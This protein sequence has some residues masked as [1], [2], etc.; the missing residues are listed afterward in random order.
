MSSRRLPLRY[1][2]FFSLLA[3]LAISIC[4]SA[5]A[6]VD[7]SSAI[8]SLTHVDAL[9]LGWAI[10]DLDGDRKLDIA[11]SQEIGR[12]G[13]G[14]LYGIELKLSHAGRL[15]SFT[16]SNPD[17]LGVSV[18]AVDVDGDHDLDLVVN[19]R[20]IG[21]RIGVWIN[22]GNGS[23]SQDLHNRHSVTER[24]WLD[25]FRIDTS[26]QP[27]EDRALQSISGVPPSTAFLLA[28]WR[29]TKVA[30]CASVHVLSCLQRGQQHLRAPP[31]PS[32]F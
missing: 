11:Q 6:T 7:S 12:S 2:C 19:G 25:S 9:G 22:D 23:F 31:I 24:P 30:A 15:Q 5:S 26:D 3:V 28:V 4:G 8:P 16:F 1:C 21:Q 32:S 27:V 20:L 17:G 29:A 18:S 14:H 13:A 10:G